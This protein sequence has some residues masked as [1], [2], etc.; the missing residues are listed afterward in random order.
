MSTTI[1]AATSPSPAGQRA[2]GRG[3]LRLLAGTALVLAIWMSALVAITRY[4]EA[5][6]SVAVIAPAGRTLASLAG[7][8]AR[9]V[10]IGAGI[11]VVDSAERGFVRLLYERGAWLVLPSRPSGCIRAGMPGLPR[12]DG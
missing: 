3:T 11:V 12:R 8:D 5:S 4:L 2:R 10:S 1:E 7:T 9:I 6:R